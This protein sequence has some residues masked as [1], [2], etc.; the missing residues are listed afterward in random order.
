MIYI[1]ADMSKKISLSKTTET[2][3]GKIPSLGDEADVESREVK[4]KAAAGAARVT[5]YEQDYETE[6]V[7]DDADELDSDD[8]SS[9]EDTKAKTIR[10]QQL[11]MYHVFS[12]FMMVRD[13]K[14]N[15]RNLAEVL[16]DVRVSIDCL[17]KCVLQ[18][19]KLLEST[20]QK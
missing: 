18:M 7:D 15:E 1:N 4:S 12:Q 11:A 6:D 10:Q 5:G 2:A 19:S 13:G 8:D 3:S 9:D 16:Q 14:G 17:T 20:T